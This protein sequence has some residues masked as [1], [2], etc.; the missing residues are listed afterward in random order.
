MPDSATPAALP[1]T[2]D[3]GCPR[4][5]EVT[6]HRPGCPNI[7]SLDGVTTAAILL[8]AQCTREEC[9]QRANYDLYGRCINCGQEVRGVFTL[10][11]EASNGV[12]G[13]ECPT[14]GVRDIQWRR[15]RP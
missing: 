10:G 4:Y 14:C 8:D 2:R 5:G 9:H 11:H 13:R 7:P 6:H 1:D 3:D 15:E 12:L